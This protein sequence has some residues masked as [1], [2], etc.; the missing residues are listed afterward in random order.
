MMKS[1]I[2]FIGILLLPLGLFLIQHTLFPPAAQ[3]RSAAAAV[4]RVN[5]PYFQG[6]VRLPETGVFWF[7]YV[8]N[9]NN[10]ADVRVGYNDEYLYIRTAVFDRRLWYDDD[11]N[12]N[13]N[14]SALPTTDAVIL[15]LDVNQ[16]GGSAPTANDYKFVGQLNWW[17]PRDNYQAG[18]RGNGT[19]W[20]PVPVSFTTT[21][22]WR[23]NAPRDDGD[24]R[25][26]NLTYEIPFTSLGLSGPPTPGTVWG[27]GMLLHDQ[28]D[29][30]NTPIDNK[31][32]PEG[33]S[34]TQPST[35]AELA[36]GLPEYTPEASISG[37]T[38]TVRHNLDGAV[39]TDAQ[40]GG[41]TVCGE[42]FGPGYFAGWGSANYAG[43][44]HMNVQNQA[45][46]ADWPCYSKSYL[47]FPLDAV[48]ANKIIIS[49]TLTLHQFGGSD[50]N[51][52]ER[53]LI[54]AFTIAQNW[55]E[56][57]ITWNNAPLALENIAAT[58]VAPTD[59]PGWPGIAVEWDV[60]SAVATAY[61]AG[62]PL[63]LA[64]YEAD[65]AYHSGKYFTTSEAEDW[66]EVARPTLRIKW[67]NP[68]FGVTVSPPVQMIT[69]G[70]TKT[71]TVNVMHG[72]GFNEAVTLTAVS[73][74]PDLLIDLS[75]TTINPPGGTATLTITDTH[76]T[77]YTSGTWYIIP[78][79]GT[80]GSIVQEAPAYVLLNGRIAFMPIILS[81][82]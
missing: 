57:T 12:L 42:S 54:Q 37:G 7:G 62:N 13:P 63:R 74:S 30:A 15:Y 66:N 23:G 56:A 31:I 81:A 16:Q 1:S 3:A 34:G 33:L 68:V 61:A 75:P 11:L 28:D 53:S 6:D 9:I 21:S 36:F 45:D 2:R 51:Q 20:T 39:V 40:V 69:P 70:E 27:L 44:P 77:G 72:T 32:W 71:F 26:W 82:P 78:I 64:L 50:P 35:W 10:Y 19:G 24:D 46:V 67:G 22:S 8:D 73:P 47:T 80:A 65:A 48:P 55:D 38:V 59:F 29:A 49:A 4:R 60:S 76:G 58:W 18:Y 17:E 5:A 52:A 43:S 25:G 41:D 79:T 14:P